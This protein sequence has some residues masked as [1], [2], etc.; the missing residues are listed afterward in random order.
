MTKRRKRDWPWPAGLTFKQ[1]IEG[2]GASNVADRS[3]N[4]SFGGD[5]YD[6]DGEEAEGKWSP[7]YPVYEDVKGAKKFFDSNGYDVPEVN[8][9]DRGLEYLNERIIELCHENEY[10]S[11]MMNYYYE[12]DL[13]HGASP[14]E[15]QARLDRYGGSCILVMV[16]GEPKLCLAGGGMDLT[17]DIAWAYILCGQLPPTKYCELPNQCEKL[18]RRNRL[19]IAACR[20]SISVH[21]RWLAGTR[22]SLEQTVR[23]MYEGKTS[24]KRGEPFG[25]LVDDADTLGNTH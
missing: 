7:I 9:N 10:F 11:P 14:E 18:S 16:S 5:T 12:I 22:R 13:R 8:D 17:W 6:V 15:A 19:T 4:Y 24:A 20:K 25:G 3:T 23:S 2:L 21:Q 1:I